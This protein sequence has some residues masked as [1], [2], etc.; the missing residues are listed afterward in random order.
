MGRQKQN[1]MNR[2]AKGRENDANE[3]KKQE[4][5]IEKPNKS[6]GKKS[7]YWFAFRTQIK[8]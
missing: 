7:I 5:G 4:N 2:L 8:S 3:R 6:S 1:V